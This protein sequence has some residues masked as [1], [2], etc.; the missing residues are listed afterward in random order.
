LRGHGADDDAGGLWHRGHSADR[1]GRVAAR[2]RP[3]GGTL[4][5]DAFKVDYGTGFD[6]AL[7]TNF[8]HH[9]DPPTCTSF[10]KKVAAALK[11]GG[12]AVVLEFVPNEDRVSPPMSASFSL[13]MLAG[14]PSGD[15]YTFPQLK[16]MA[17]DAGY[18]SVSAHPLPMPETVIVATK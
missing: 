10:L 5:G 7:I 9:F 2:A 8:L 11:P 4:P 16:K 13:T 6:V 12:K 17:I 3:C 14:T 1:L 15:A 18:T